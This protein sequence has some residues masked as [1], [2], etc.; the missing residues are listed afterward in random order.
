MRATSLSVLLLVTALAPA[1]ARPA[2]RR[3]PARPPGSRPAS[4][5]ASKPPGPDLP[6]RLPPAAPF[7]VVNGERIPIAAYIDR[8]SIRYGPDVR[9]QLIEETLIRQEA[10]KRK[11]R[12]TVA[13]MEAVSKRAYEASVRQ[14]GDEQRLAE[15]LRRARGWT[16]A[17]YRWVIR[18]EA[19]VQVL[20]E[21]LAAS[22]FDP[23]TL[24]DAEIETR[25]NELR[26]RFTE[27]DRVRIAQIFVRRPGE[28]EPEKDLAARRRAEELLKRLTEGAAFEEVARQHSEDRITGPQGGMLPVEIRRGEHPYGAAFEAAVFAAP[29]G[30]IREVI[31]CP[32]GFR[33]V[34]VDA[35]TPGRVIPLAEAKEKVRAL[36]GAE[37]RAQKLQELLLRLRVQARVET[38]RF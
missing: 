16:P 21:K 13:E 27:P 5:P 36:L 30:L 37:R 8:L 1:F 19:E 18:N 28:A 31:A 2:P 34:R 10:R 12:A 29:P 26:D 25:Y 17:D 23:A 9:E 4:G 35:R 33:I 14:Y 32:D 22:L 24:T 7:C 3:V 38:G 6:S 20:R 15:E 11:L